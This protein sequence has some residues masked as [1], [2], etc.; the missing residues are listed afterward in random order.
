MITVQILHDN[1]DPLFEGTHSR[2][3][4]YAEENNTNRVFIIR[5]SLGNTRIE[6]IIL[7]L[8]YLSSICFNGT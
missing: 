3:Y 2:L 1:A 4:L 8:L 6:Y 5:R 7:L